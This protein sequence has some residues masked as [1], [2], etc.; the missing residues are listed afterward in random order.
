MGD[1][2]TIYWTPDGWEGIGLGNPIPVAGGSGFVGR[3]LPGSRVFVTNVQGGLF[4]LVG[5]FTV[6]AVVETAVSGKPAK[7]TWDAPEYLLAQ[8]G[9]S[10]PVRPQSIPADVVRSLRFVTS[11]GKESAVKF[12]DDGRVNGQA[13]RAVRQLTPESALILEEH[14]ERAAEKEWSEEELRA[15]VAAYLDM[16]RRRAAGEPFVK[17]DVYRSLVDQFGRTTGSFE[18]RMQNISYVLSLLG[19]DWL[20]GLPP[21]KNVGARVAAVI[22]RLIGEVEMRPSV[23]VVGDTIEVSKE[24]RTIAARPAGNKTPTATTSSVTAYARD[25]KVKAWVLRRS[26]GSCE[27]CGCAAPFVGVDGFP[28]LE[29]HHVR[30]LADAGSDTVSNAVALCPNCHRRLHFSEDAHVYREQLFDKVAELQ[31]E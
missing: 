23:P 19:R 15:S 6:Q 12:D 3:V 4:R 20:P 27:A 17:K 7:A 5:A 31:R 26:G 28:F 16:S 9:T 25:A 24:R 22:E 21:A 1:A 30:K 2:F 13:M 10:S 29:V 14:L 18:Y 8:E 11:A